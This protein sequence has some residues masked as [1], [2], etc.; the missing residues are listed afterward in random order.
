MSGKPGNGRIRRVCPLS[1]QRRL[2]VVVSPC[3]YF[4][5][6]VPEKGTTREGARVAAN[7]VRRISLCHITQHAAYDVAH[8]QAA[9]AESIRPFRARVPPRQDDQ[10]SLKGNRGATVAANPV[11]RIP[12]ATSTHTAAPRPQ[13]CPAQRRLLHAC[14]RKQRSSPLAS[15]AASLR[16]AL[17]RTG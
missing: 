16:T 12:C 6:E 4:D 14:S 7:P 17:G 5:S 9:G 3:C 2:V 8:A 15:R 1:P 11:R 10:A 13:L